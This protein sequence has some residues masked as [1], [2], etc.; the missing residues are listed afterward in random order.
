MSWYDPIK[1]Y[2]FG[3]NATQSVDTKPGHYDQATAQLGQIAQGA[4]GR[5]APTAAGV[6]LGGPSQLAPE[7]MNQSRAGMLGVANQLGGIA[8]GQQAGAG[9]LAVNRQLGQATA[10]QQAAARMSRGA[11]A[12][13]AFRNAA[14]NTADLGLQGAGMA[15]TAQ[16]ADQQSALGQQAGIYGSM[17]GQD[18]NVAAQNAQLGQQVTLQQG[19]MDQQTQLANLQARLAQTGMNDQQQIQALGQILGWD[20]AKIDAELKRAAINAGDKG[21]L[22]GLIAGGSQV[23][24]AAAA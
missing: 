20:Q 4:A 11:N 14:R 1:D 15:A 21:I 9:E 23:A 19:S 2:I 5:P 18:A 7:Q 16:A 3:G 13:L 12:A 10:A 6:H 17:Y 22:P 24:A 8:S